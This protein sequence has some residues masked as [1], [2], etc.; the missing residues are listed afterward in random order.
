MFKIIV[1]LLKNG[2]ASSE[3][4]MK[5]TRPSDSKR[6]L[7]M[8]KEQNKIN[9]F[10]NLIFKYISIMA[11]NHY[12]LIIL[13]IFIYKKNTQENHLY[14][15]RLVLIFLIFVFCF[16]IYIHYFLLSWRLSILLAA[17]SDILMIG[18]YS[19]IRTYRRSLGGNHSR[20]HI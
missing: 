15:L 12:L 17:L 13:L 16:Y 1:Y 8:K 7:K 19:H 5:A 10:L 18:M 6:I 2:M 14:G 4:P 9:F 3:E 11:T 20:S